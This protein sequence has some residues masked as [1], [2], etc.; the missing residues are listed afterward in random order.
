MEPGFPWSLVE[1]A[2]LGE[3]RAGVR[4]PC[5]F[6]DASMLGL[7]LASPAVSFSHDDYR[8]AFDR[9]AVQRVRAL[10]VKNFATAVVSLSGR[11]IG[12][13]GAIVPTGRTFSTFA[14]VVV[15]FDAAGVQSLAVESG[16]V[17]K[18]TACGLRS[19]AQS[20]SE[21]AVSSAAERADLLEGDA[22]AT[23]WARNWRLPPRLARLAVLLMAG[24]SPRA[25]GERTGLSLRSV[26][27]YTEELFALAGV[28][29]RS[30]LGPRALRDGLALSARIESTS[31]ALS[32]MGV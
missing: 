18:L 31:S 10:R 4:V 19:R 7:A 11:Q 29:C 22:S 17:R 27:T 14:H 12:V 21:L 25:V 6:R 30:E 23:Y 16:L 3:P 2:L 9:R 24:L 32:T 15:R 8:A 5:V 1:D 26:R 13:L 28:H 20:E